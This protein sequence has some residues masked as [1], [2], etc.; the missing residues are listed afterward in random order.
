MP[1]KNKVVKIIAFVILAI[2]LLPWVFTLCLSIWGIFAGAEVG[3]FEAARKVYGADAFMYTWVMYWFVFMPVFVITAITAI[4][5]TVV[6]I[7]IKKKGAAAGKKT[8]KVIMT[9]GKICSGK[10]TYARKMREEYKAVILSV[11]DITLAMFGQDVGD[12][13]DEYVG[14]LEEYLFGKSVEIVETGT[15]VV[16]DWGFWLRS[17]RDYARNFYAK[18]GIAFELHYINVSD[19]E[20]DRRLEKR[21]ADVTAGRIIAYYVD[22]GLKA[23]FR[24]MFEPPEENE[25]D[26]VINA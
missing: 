11:D 22:D 10:S 5:S 12:K 16:L 2:S 26:A 24:E 7:V 13:H 1:Q 8:P 14:K 9:C 25:C 23:K 21:N 6:L 18:H 3:L 19:E 15:N 17:E 4:I 20:W